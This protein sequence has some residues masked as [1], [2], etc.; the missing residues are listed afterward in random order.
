MGR[1]MVVAGGAADERGGE[2][3]GYADE[4]EAEDVVERAGLFGHYY[5]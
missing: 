1:R 3:P 4:D 2:T 5:G